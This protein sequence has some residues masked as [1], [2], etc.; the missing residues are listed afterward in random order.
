MI[1][2]SAYKFCAPPTTDLSFHYHLCDE[3]GPLLAIDASYHAPQNFCYSLDICILDRCV[4]TCYDECTFLIHRSTPCAQPWPGMEKLE[5]AQLE[6]SRPKHIRIGASSTTYSSSS[7]QQNI[8]GKLTITPATTFNFLSAENKEQKIRIILK[9]WIIGFN[10]IYAALRRI[11][12]ETFS[13]T[14]ELSCSIIV[15]GLQH[16]SVVA[17]QRRCNYIPTIVFIRHVRTFHGHRDSFNARKRNYSVYK[18][19]RIDLEPVGDVLCLSENVMVITAVPDYKRAVRFVRQNFLS[20][21]HRYR[22]PIPT[23]LKNNPLSGEIH[24]IVLFVVRSTRSSVHVRCLR[25]RRQCAAHCRR[26]RVLLAVAHLL[27]ITSILHH[28][29]S[30]PTK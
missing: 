9:S 17:L 24:H 30:S 7:P 1:G 27:N 13:Q 29:L 8:P 16:Y 5:M 26:G 12:V 23:I 14:E 2:S 15:Q 25:Q 21:F 18:M 11:Y 3:Y 19:K 4:L 6:A 20:S 28:G 10:E 22:T